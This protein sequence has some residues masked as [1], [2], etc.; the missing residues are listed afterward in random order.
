[1][2]KKVTKQGSLLRSEWQIVQA[3]AGNVT[4]LSHFYQFLT[5]YTAAAE[6][7]QENL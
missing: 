1:V 6:T 4:S 7:V 2:A 3:V 5:L